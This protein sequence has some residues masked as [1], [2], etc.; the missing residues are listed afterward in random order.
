[1]DACGQDVAGE[2]DE[3]ATGDRGGTGT[4]QG[5]GGAIGDGMLS[6][7]P[8]GMRVGSCLSVFTCLSG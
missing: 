8:T 6:A 1:M 2:L 7:R 4:D 3:L 5:Y